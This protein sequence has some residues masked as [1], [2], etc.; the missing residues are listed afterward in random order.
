M[1][2][3][4]QS[5]AQISAGLDTNHIGAPKG[6]RRFRSLAGVSQR[7]FS[8]V[9]M[10]A[11]TTLLVF[12][13]EAG[14]TTNE[15]AVVESVDVIPI[16]GGDWLLTIEAR[17]LRPATQV[18]MSAWPSPHAT[19]SVID[20]D[21]VHVDDGLVVASFL[22]KEVRADAA[23]ISL[24]LVVQ[25][26]DLRLQS[27]LRVF[28]RSRG[29]H[30]EAIGPDTDL[31]P[32]F[33]SD[34]TGLTSRIVFGGRQI[35]RPE[36]SLPVTS[37]LVPLGLRERLALMSDGNASS[38]KQRKSA[39]RPLEEA[40]VQ[41]GGCSGSSFSPLLVLVLFGLF[42]YARTKAAIGACLLGVISAAPQAEAAERC[43]FGL[44][45]FWDARRIEFMDPTPYVE[46]SYPGFRD[47]PCDTGD[48]S[49]SAFASGCCFKPLNGVNVRLLR[50][51]I[52]PWPP[53][54]TLV[55]QHNT[56]IY[57]GFILLCDPSWQSF[58][59]YTVEVVF[60]HGASAPAQFEFRPSPGTTPIYTEYYVG[61]LTSSP[62]TIGQLSI[63]PPGDPSDPLTDITNNWATAYEAL[64]ALEA[65][66]EARIRRKF[67]SISDFDKINFNLH[68]SLTTPYASCDSTVDF[69]LGS[70][71]LHHELG[72]ILEG[73]L[74][75]CANPFLNHGPFDPHDPFHATEASSFREAYATLVAMFRGFDS[76]VATTHDVTVESFGGC[77]S[78]THEND[79]VSQFDLAQGLWNLFDV[80]SGYYDTSAEFAVYQLFEFNDALISLASSTGSPGLNRTV[81]ERYWTLTGGTCSPS[82]TTSPCSFTPCANLAYACANDGRC[83]SG[84]PHG[85][86]ARDIMDFMTSTSTAVQAFTSSPCIG[87]SDD[88]A[89]FA[90]GY[91][92]Y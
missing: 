17:T 3:T 21:V 48:Q 43:V 40:E 62:H 87:G 29:G 50:R 85:G 33:V 1:S 69:D 68:A 39:F 22:L 24:T 77:N 66:G 34:E 90:H 88:S 6:N 86:N 18:R 37:E 13:P 4:H 11:A 41:A 23:L 10:L 8:T 38:E 91:R 32:F 36:L 61:A 72:H 60:Q 31:S 78:I 80:D 75:G 67:G 44:A 7:L 81:N 20:Q 26:P 49:C 64:Q 83:Y 53:T 12:S 92:Y 14:A 46:T 27:M 52:V 56:D 84:D 30:L 2:A 42:R 76:A 51:S 57:G 71:A 9:V 59:T 89:P 65:Q 16:E 70:D 25:A 15:L 55:A 54:S 79:S 63:N 73:R 82:C 47:Q 45:A 28:I 19:I 5:T 74:L 35:H 58:Y